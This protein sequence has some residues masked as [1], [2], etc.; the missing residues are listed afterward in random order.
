MSIVDI[1]N[2]VRQTNVTQTIHQTPYDAISI[3]RPELSQAGRS[4][5]IT[6][7]GT[8]AGFA[9]AQ[10]FIRASAATVIIIGRRADVL[11]SARLKLEDIAKTAS[12]GTKIITRTCDIVKMS[13]VNALWQYFSDE[14]IVV[15]VYVSNAAA[16][17]DPST[18]MNLG[19]DALW[20]IVETNF[21]SPIYFTEKFSKQGGD[22]QKVSKL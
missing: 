19:A 8:G 17:S 13:D 18:M 9:I 6:G 12:T 10:S 11:N 22:K 1:L 21:K 20:S 5:L 7:G 16:F 15:D 3:T 4:V 14:D 2:E